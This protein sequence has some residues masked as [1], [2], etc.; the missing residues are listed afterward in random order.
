MDMALDS[1]VILRN[2]IDYEYFIYVKSNKRNK[3]P[4]E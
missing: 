1:A 2:D 3:A 4:W